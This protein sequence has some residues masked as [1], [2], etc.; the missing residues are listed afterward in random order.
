MEKFVINLDDEVYTCLA[1]EH[2]HATV[3]N[4]M[5]HICRVHANRRV[6]TRIEPRGPEVFQQ[7]SDSAVETSSQKT[8]QTVLM[9]RFRKQ[10]PLSP[11]NLPRGSRS[12][13][14]LESCRCHRNQN[15]NRPFYQV[16][17]IHLNLR[18]VTLPYETVKSFFISVRDS[19][20]LPILLRFNRTGHQK[21]WTDT[22]WTKHF[23][24][25][26]EV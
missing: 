19:P 13:L 3:E 1:C 17:K 7:D 8:V 10:N 5:D 21:W 9:M 25:L 11:G 14:T 4:L 18:R 15:A 20:L 26:G 24:L 2:K 16:K 22:D 6:Q 23:S 12:L